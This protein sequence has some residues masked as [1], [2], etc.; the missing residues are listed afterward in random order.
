MNAYTLTAIKTD[1]NQIKK[2]FKFS[3][4][5]EAN[6]ALKAELKSGRVVQRGYDYFSSKFGNLEIRSNY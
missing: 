6:K 2:V 3:S 4:K 5:R 1:T